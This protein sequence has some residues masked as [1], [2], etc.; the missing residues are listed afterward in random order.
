MKKN[1]Q[2]ALFLI[3][4][5]AA[6]I[7]TR[8]L[9]P[10]SISPSDASGVVLSPASSAIAVPTSSQPSTLSSPDPVGGDISGGASANSTTPYSGETNI[11][12]SV[13]SR[14]ETTLVPVFSQHA[15]LVA[16][17]TNGVI[18]AQNNSGARWP[19]A[20]LTK[21]MTAT[22]V[23]DHLSTSTEITITPQMF[24]VYPQEGTL[25]V[26]GTYTVS[27]LLH[28]MLMP[29]SNVAAEAMADYYGRAVFLAEMNQRAQAWGMTSTYFDDPS[30]LSSANQSSA[31]DLMTLAQHIYKDYPQ[32]LAITRTP[33]TT[34]TN[35]NSGKTY[36]VKSINNFAGET[37]FIGGKTGYTNEAE[38]NLLSIFSYH[39]NPVLVIVLGVTDRFGDTT[40]LLNWF[41][42]NYQ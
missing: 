18:L 9:Y 32:V 42:M 21:L 27:D 15:S 1:Y 23:L 2:K 17:L 41:T 33:E 11:A 6:A 13:F 4:I 39:G 34:I 5:V 3:V 14:A 19:T 7:L 24:A 22:I 28:T 35:L 25:V 10:V 29:S 20:S 12:G 37:N 38:D 16:D 40:K 30:G 8:F 36:D 31:S 26:N